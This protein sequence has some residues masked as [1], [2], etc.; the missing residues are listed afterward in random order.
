MRRSSP[1]IIVLALTAFAGCSDTPDTTGPDRNG[2][3]RDSGGRGDAGAPDSTDNDGSGDA[4]PSDDVVSDTSA[5][6]AAVCEI[7]RRRC[8]SV[9]TAQICTDGTGWLD[10]PCGAGQVCIPDTGDCIDAL[11]VPDSS[12]CVDAQNRR[13]CSPDGQSWSEPRPCGE[14]RYC[15]DGSCEEVVCLPQVMFLIDGSSSMV[16]EWDAVR[17]SIAAVTAANPD[18]AFGLSMFPTAIGCS[19]GDGDPGLFGGSAVT[20]PH[21]PISITGAAD[22]EAWFASN[23]A[24]GG[25]TP[26]ASSIEWFSENP[27][28]V[29]GA[30]PENGYLI[31][32]SEGADTCRCDDGDD[33]AVEL[34]NAT[35]ALL[36]AGVRTYVIG[37]RFGDSPSSLN[38]IAENGGTSITEFIYAGS[39]ETLTDAFETIVADVKLCEE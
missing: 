15:S 19:I 2:P 20:W 14:G 33:C 16:R 28:A 11:C 26:L 8:A 25:A 27:A 32:M 23:D 37:Y 4:A 10:E 12:E 9:D 35:S 29:W 38:A 31:V 6:D 1:A 21:V 36:A 5:P 34:R 18:V 22:I 3:A 17:A 13:V 39:E 7:G 24:S 30:V